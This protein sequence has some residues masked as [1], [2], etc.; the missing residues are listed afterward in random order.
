M[1]AVIFWV[2]ALTGY[3]LG[4]HVAAVACTTRNE[5]VK[6][7]LS[8]ATW[9]ALVVLIVLVGVLIGGAA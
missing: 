9:I 5:H 6:T 7:A 3:M 4:A 2:I 1:S 8:V